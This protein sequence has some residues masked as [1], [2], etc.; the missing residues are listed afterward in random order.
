MKS[1]Y[2]MSTRHPNNLKV[3]QVNQSSFGTKS[4]RTLG[5]KIWNELPE[6][7]KSAE[8]LEIFKRIIKMWKGPN[9]NCSLCRFLFSQSL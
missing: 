4:L 6:E 9:C 8:S 7:I 2:R 1:S 3:P 5:P